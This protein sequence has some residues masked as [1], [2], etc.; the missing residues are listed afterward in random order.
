[1]K[2]NISDMIIK[3]RASD[4]VLLRTQRAQVGD[5]ILSLGPTRANSVR[6]AD[7]LIWLRRRGL[8]NVERKG[9]HTNMVN[10]TAA[11]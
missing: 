5:V 6:I 4:T 2:P 3:P 1:M 8:E 7:D 9:R 10:G 11:G